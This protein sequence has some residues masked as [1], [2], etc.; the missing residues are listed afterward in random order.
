MSRIVNL[1]SPYPIKI[2]SADP[3]RTLRRATLFLYVWSGPI[4]NRP[5]EPTFRL[6]KGINPLEDFII[7]DVADYCRDFIELEFDNRTYRTDPVYVGIEVAKEYSNTTTND[8]ESHLFWGLDGYRDHAQGLDGF[9]N[10]IRVTTPNDTDT[11]MDELI[12][13]TVSLTANGFSTQSQFIPAGNGVTFNFAVNPPNSTVTL[14]RGSESNVIATVG[15]EDTKTFTISNFQ[16]ANEGTYFA[17]ASYT[18]TDGSQTVLTSERSNAIALSIQTDF[19]ATL[20]P[21]SNTFTAA[22]GDAE[23]YTLRIAASDTAPVVSNVVFPSWLDISGFTDNVVGAIRT[24][25]WILTTDEANTSTSSRSGE[26]TVTWNT[27]ANSLTASVTQAGDAAMPPTQPTITAVRD[28]TGV[29]T[30]TGNS[31]DTFT[32]T[33]SGSTDPE[34]GT[35]SYQWYLN[36]T[37]PGNRI[38]GATGATFITTENAAGTRS[39]TVGATSSVTGLTTFA[40]AVSIQHRGGPT[41]AFQANQVFES[42]QT[43]NVGVVASDPASGTLTYTWEIDEGSGFVPLNTSSIHSSGG[44]INDTTAVLSSTSQVTVRVRVRATSSVTG[45]VSPWTGGVNGTTFTFTGAGSIAQ[46]TNANVAFAS[47]LNPNGPFAVSTNTVVEDTYIRVTGSF[48]SAD[49]LARSETNEVWTRYTDSSYTTVAE[50]FEGISTITRFRSNG[51]TEFWRYE[52]INELSGTN[53]PR[54][55]FQLTWSTRLIA[56]WAAQGIVS[57]DQTNQTGVTTNFNKSAGVDVSNYSVQ[58][59]DTGDGTNWITNIVLTQM[60]SIIGVATYDVLRNN[61]NVARS[62]T[63]RIIVTVGSQTRSQDIT[64]TQ[65]GNVA[66]QITSFGVFPT[67]SIPST[68]ELIRVEIG[69][70]NAGASW[71]L[72]VNI[73]NGTDQQFTGTGTDVVNVTI[74]SNPNTVNRNIDFTL[75]RIGATTFAPGLVNEQTRVQFGRSTGGSRGTDNAQ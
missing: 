50:S 17:I 36:G 33:A 12:T 45:L 72:D 11:G 43:I 2:E 15:P 69:S 59:I 34:G 24:I 28:T 20:T 31:G 3:S 71:R 7:F 56:S 54:E 16:A 39:Y 62:L 66:G 57:Y 64:I 55:D 14:Y 74:P 41:I 63:A 1:R 51:G 4:T 30:N 58:L 26:V 8:T 46:N 49:Q 13:P 73:P 23:T 68:S 22:A 47:S 53:A 25:T 52:P 60:T 38:E 6:A 5:L 19:E 18:N 75:N 44:G 29:T 37:S 10:L 67:G 32:L 9:F 70:N 61:A 40:M 27:G 21:E 65:S 48:D 35:I 42:A